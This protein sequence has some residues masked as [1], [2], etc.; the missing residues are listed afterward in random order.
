MA[1]HRLVAHCRQDLL[2]RLPVEVA[3]EVADG[4]DD[5]FEEYLSRGLTPDQAA[6]A[7]VAEFGDPGQIV[8][9]FRR[10]SPVRRLA[11]MLVLTGPL[12]GGWWAAALISSRAWDWSIPLSARLVAG[13][14]VAAS[15]AL[16]MTALL[17][18][19][20][21]AL[22]RAGIAG[23]LGVAALDAA[24][25]TTVMVLAPDGRWLF[26]VA[27]CLSAVRLTFVARSLRRILV[28]AG[29]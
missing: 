5:S 24:V 14:L 2:Q 11:R 9:A 23:C 7:A 4:L 21:Q 12:V 26:I 27:A 16:L 13:P 1:S 17:S 3:E 25:I 18:R 20:Y 28:Q 10:A 6:T 19:R 8:D 15:V 22:Q 29:M